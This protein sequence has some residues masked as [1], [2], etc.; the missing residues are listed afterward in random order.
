MVLNAIG[1]TID[2][3]VTLMASYEYGVSVPRD[4]VVV[5]FHADTDTNLL[6]ESVHVDVA[7]PLLYKP[8]GGFGIF[9]SS[10]ACFEAANNSALETA[11]GGIAVHANL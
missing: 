3:G 7:P 9:G 1:T 11:G 4:H 5:G 8:T 2:I 6:D 10:A